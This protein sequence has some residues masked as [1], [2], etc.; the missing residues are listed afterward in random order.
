M[1][2][3]SISSRRVPAG[4][5]VYEVNGPFFFG[6]ADKVKDV[7]RTVVG[8]P[9][10][11]ILRMRNVPAMDATGIHALLDLRRKCQREGSTLILSEIHTQPLFALD[12]SGHYEEFGRDNITAHIDD[13]LNRARSILGLPEV[14]TEERRVPEVARDRNPAEVIKSAAA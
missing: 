8:K 5:E 14:T 1:L 10:A 3:R 9:K 11:F 4:V 7:L 12:R 13:A 6:V 2:F